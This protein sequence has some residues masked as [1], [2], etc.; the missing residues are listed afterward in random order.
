[1]RIVSTVSDAIAA[2]PSGGTVFI[3]SA[4][5]VPRALVRGLDESDALPGGEIVAGYL[6]ADLPLT[7]ADLSVVSLQP[8][9]ALWRSVASADV[10]PVRY[11]DYETLFDRLDAVLI[12]VSLPGPDGRYSLGTSVGAA[13][14]AIE[15][16]DLVIAQI[17]RCMPYTFGDAELDPGAIDVAVRVDEPLAELPFRPPTPSD[18]AIANTVA[19]LIPAGAC[20]Q[21]GVGTLPQRVGG[22]LAERKPLIRS[23]MVSDWV[24][25][26]AGPIVAAEAVGTAALYRWLDRNPAVRMVRAS[27]THIAPSTDLPFFAMNSALEIDLAG[28]VNAERIGERLVSGP[29][30]MPDF[31]SIALGSPGGANI[32][33]LPATAAGGTRSTVVREVGEVTLPTWM[34]DTFVTEFGVASVRGLPASQRAQAIRAI[35]APNFRDVLDDRQEVAQWASTRSPHSG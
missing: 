21:L 23:G 9:A 18:E 19:A 6:V 29:G 2:L 30:G 11:S 15:Q 16:A 33:M 3:G 1:M 12:Q 5:G 20:V 31:A 28:R 22:L 35:A 14:P 25:A 13:V 24:L 32:V 7:R 27:T 4:T 26:M 17:N 8:S 10:A 34:A